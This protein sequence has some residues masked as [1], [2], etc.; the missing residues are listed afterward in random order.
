MSDQITEQQVFTRKEA[1]KYLRVGLSTFDKLIS[2]VLPK[3]FIGSRGYRIRK[4]ALD[5]YLQEQEVR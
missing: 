3:V 1:A 4:Q 2:P 5:R